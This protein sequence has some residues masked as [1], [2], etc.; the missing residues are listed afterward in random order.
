[1]NNAY[2]TKN[3]GRN[4]KEGFLSEIEWSNNDGHVYLHQAIKYKQFQLSVYIFFVLYH[5]AEVCDGK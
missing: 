2:K 4:M 1:M 3:M 5:F